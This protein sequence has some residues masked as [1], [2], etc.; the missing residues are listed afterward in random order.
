VNTK[1]AFFSLIIIF[2][3]FF[4]FGEIIV[5]F[6]FTQ[7]DYGDFRTSAFYKPSLSLPLEL[8]PN[9]DCYLKGLDFDIRVKTN[10]LG[11]RC[12]E[13][14]QEKS[15]DALRLLCLGDSFIFGWGVNYE[16]SFC[17]RLKG[18]LSK[19]IA[20]GKKTQNIEVIN[21]GFADGYSPDSYDLY[22]R[23]EGL[24]LQ[25]DIV[26]VGIFVWNDLSDIL[27]NDW[28]QVDKRGLPL[29]IKSRVYEID[30]NGNRVSTSGLPWYRRWPIVKNSQLLAYL[31]R[32]PTMF[33]YIREIYKNARYM[34]HDPWPIQLQEAMKK[35][36]IVMEDIKKQC[37]EAKA[38]LLVLLIPSPNQLPGGEKYDFIYS[39]SLVNAKNRFY[40]QECFK[41][42]LQKLNIAFYDTYHILS[43][44][45]TMEKKT[46]DDYYFRFNGHWR[47]KSHL[48]IA[49]NIAKVIL[50]RMKKYE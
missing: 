12:E 20:A 35:F 1:K 19:L 13:F 14:R 39:A 28:L 16:D 42:S 15:R 7:A 46:V 34:F 9:Q 6:F 47:P 50:T 27:D 11:Y 2:F 43:E 49:Q 4:L 48:L 5:R 32:K 21:A 26:L 31:L 18:E 36:E 17:F 8:S 45:M 41:K 37:D 44:D 24:S 23:K 3:V 25:P 40:P 10:S 33:F 30:K 22:L 38:E 29:K